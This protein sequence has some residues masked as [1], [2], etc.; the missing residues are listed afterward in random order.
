[1][2]AHSSGPGGLRVQPGIEYSGGG[3]TIHRVR[4]TSEDGTFRKTYS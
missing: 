2:F 3:T 4:K 1:V